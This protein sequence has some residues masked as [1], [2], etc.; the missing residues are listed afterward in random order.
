[1]GRHGRAY[2]VS[3]PSSAQGRRSSA[4]S[5]GS[6]SPAKAVADLVNI[7][8]GRAEDRQLATGAHVVADISCIGCNNVVG[9]KYVDARDPGQ[10][11]KIGKFILETRKVVGF[12]TWE[13]VDIPVVGEE[14]GQFDPPSGASEDADEGDGV[15]VFDSE[16]EDECEDIFAAVWD[17]KV[18]ARRRKSKVMNMRRAGEELA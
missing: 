16:D 14:D 10:H 17:P 12:H 11:Y 8:V 5:L 15:V 13:D 9:W 1:M 18:V 4:S 3:P 2:L 7:R 6:P